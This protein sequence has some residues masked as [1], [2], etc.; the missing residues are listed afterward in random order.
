MLILSNKSISVVKQFIQEN[1]VL[2][3]RYM[4]LAI[5]DAIRTKKKRAEFFSFGRNSENVAIA[6]PMDYE[7]I[8]NDA[9]SHFSK[10]EEYEFAA[11]ARDI[12]RKWKVE[13]LLND[14]SSE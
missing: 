1:E 8:L 2:V 5:A 9:I 10:A 7:T 13:Q 3:Y 6:K 4:V 14:D 11:H 12:L